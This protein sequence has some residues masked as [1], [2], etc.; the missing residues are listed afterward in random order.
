ML[1][2]ESLNRASEK[3]HFGYCTVHRRAVAF[4]TAGCITV[5]W[6]SLACMRSLACVSSFACRGWVSLHVFC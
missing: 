2:V 5:G 3:S 4:S 1:A 6:D